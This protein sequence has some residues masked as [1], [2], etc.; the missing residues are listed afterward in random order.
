[1]NERRLNFWGWGYEDEWPTGQ[2]LSALSEGLRQHI[3]F[4]SDEL[5][6]PVRLDQIE[7]PSPKLKPPTALAK[8]CS[9][10]V[11]DRVTHAYGKSYRDVIRAFRGRFDHPP[12]VVAYPSNEREVENLLEWCVDQ[13]AAAIPFGGGTSVVGGVEPAVGDGYAGTVSIDLKRMDQVL[14]VDSV[15]QAARIQ[16]GA[17][18]PK[19]EDQLKPH[20]LNLRHYPQSYE[21]STLGGWIATRSAGHFATLNT[22]IDEFV[23]SLR[24]LTPEGLWESRRLPASGAGPSPDRLL[25]GSEG[26]LGVITESWVRVHARPEYRAS[27]VMHF[28]DFKSGSRA[29]REIGQAG[30]YPANCRLVDPVEAALTGTGG[31]DRAVLL[32]SFE[33][34]DHPVDEW[35]SVAVERCRE[36][37]GTEASNEGYDE[38]G[39]LLGVEP[40]A[41]QAD[42]WRDAF[43]RAPYLRDIMVA[44]GVVVETFE[45][46][47]TWDRF[48]DFHSV[49][50]EA[51][52]QAVV[53]VCGTGM[54]TCRLTH[55]YPD[56]VAPYFTVL[57]PAKRGSELE[58]W[59]EVKEA[60]SE[61]VL[62]NGGTI[63]HHHAIGRDHRQWYDRQRP[64]PFAEALAAAKKALDPAWVLNP[65]VLLDRT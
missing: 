41:D 52:K 11:Y 57:A 7:L 34:A 43:L 16:A 44:M 54:V 42:S 23:E 8:I 37:G 46:A 26:T 40:G 30:L 15:S 48:E 35:L 5:E 4:G 9:S 21:F 10:T 17:T 22:H 60:A 49:V 39:R 62:A 20:G 3:G 25:V 63:T 36:H 24:V 55:V 61:A 29:V 2:Q 28:P 6:L 19:L 27:S 32:L 33:S 12:D 59:R 14:D 38:T 1:M 53:G 47:V 51:V 45:T 31:G 58:Q 50:I 64:Q 13:S 56:G 65:G 18:G